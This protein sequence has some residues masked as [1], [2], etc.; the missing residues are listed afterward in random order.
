MTGERCLPNGVEQ[1]DDFHRTGFLVLPGFF[2]A[3]EV[4]ALRT[5]AAQV[6]AEAEQGLGTGHQYRESAEGRKY[7]RTDDLR[8]RHQAFRDA[9]TK[10]VLLSAIGQCV[11]HPFLPMGEAIVVKLPGSPVTIPWHQDPPYL[12]AEGIADTFG[13]PN[14]DVDIYLDKSDEAAGCLYGIPEHHLVGRVEVTEQAQDKTFDRPDVVQLSQ[15][16]GDVVFHA[17]S[18]PHGSRLNTGTSIRR[19]LY[20][21]YMAAEVLAGCY[22][23]WGAGDPPVVDGQFTAKAVDAF[24]AMLAERNSQPDEPE[25]A[26]EQVEL[27][28]RGIEFTG[29][30]ITEPWHWQRLIGD[31]SPQERAAK[32]K[33]E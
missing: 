21:H 2:D 5:A 18:A 8:D 14:F 9:I 17:I 29:V 12:G 4:E 1:I 33:L 6:Q 31:I 3:A 20:L 23:E 30:P 27:T 26:A 24:A 16:P 13:V 19:I 11:G 7:F 25:L 28:E 32:K 15:Q 10:P 22:P